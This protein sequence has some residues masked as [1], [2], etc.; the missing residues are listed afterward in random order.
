MYKDEILAIDL[1]RKGVH[2]LLEE[3]EPCYYTRCARPVD[4]IYRAP[5]SSLESCC[6]IGEAEYC[7]VGQNALLKKKPV[8]LLKNAHSV[9]ASV[10][11]TNGN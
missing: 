1:A 5:A 4:A 10:I 3:I 8:F 7:L 9:V 6:F 2:L 11:T